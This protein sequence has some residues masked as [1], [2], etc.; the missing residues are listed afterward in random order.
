[1]E[2]LSLDPKLAALIQRVGAKTLIANIGEPMK[3]TQA[4]LF[5]QCLRA[6]TF[7][8][9]SVLAG[10]S[11]M[12][13][14]AI[15]I[16]VCLEM[17]KPLARKRVLEQALAEMQ[18][19]SNGFGKWTLKKLHGCLLDGEFGKI[20]FTP[21][22]LR[23]L[24]A[25]CQAPNGKPGY[26][27]LWGGKFRPQASLYMIDKLLYDEKVPPLSCVERIYSISL[28]CHAYR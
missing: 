11:F 15:K 22:L 14:L 12:R 17:L 28:F 16:G 10:N 9:V 6:I 3:P 4:S 21:S 7:T 27:H 8:M 25:A 23:P 5:D 20:I 13:K 18:E 26:P 24:L 1:M 19:A 2:Q